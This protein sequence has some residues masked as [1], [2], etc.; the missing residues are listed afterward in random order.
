MKGNFFA[1]EKR[2]M[3]SLLY[4]KRR[5]VFSYAYGWRIQD[6]G[7]WT[8][9]KCVTMAKV[10]RSCS[11]LQQCCSQH[12]LWHHNAVRQQPYETE[13]QQYGR[14]L[15]SVSILLTI[16]QQ[17]FACPCSSIPYYQLAMLLV[18]ACFR[19]LPAIL[20]MICPQHAT[21]SITCNMH[22]CA[23]PS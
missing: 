11:T 4:G 23:L 6:S 7:Y 1:C 19:S 2:H 17:H 12:Y 8:F 15:P 16:C 3:F 20:A 14:P 9:Q 5:H 13:M 22:G 21:H 18:H 10:M